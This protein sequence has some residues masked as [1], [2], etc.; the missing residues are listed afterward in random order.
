MWKMQK[1]G[2][3]KSPA[4]AALFVQEPSTAHR[5]CCSI[6]SC[7]NHLKRVGINTSDY[8]VYRRSLGHKVTQ[9]INSF[10]LLNPNSPRRNR[11][12]TF[13]PLSHISV[14]LF[15]GLNNNTK[16]HPPNNPKTA[17]EHHVPETN[18]AFDTD[19]EA[20]FLTQLAPL[21]TSPI[22]TI[23]EDP[24][25]SRCPTPPQLQINESLLESAESSSRSSRRNSRRCSGERLP[26]LVT[27]GG[28]M[29]IAF[30]L[31]RRNSYCPTRLAPPDR[32]ELL[33][34]ERKTRS[35][36][37]SQPTIVRTSS[38]R[39][40]HVSP[41]VRPINLKLL[42][43]EYSCDHLRLFAV[44]FFKINWRIVNGFTNHR[45]CNVGSAV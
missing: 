3:W 15:P 38:E 21:S 35:E 43:L 16:T 26:C 4:N 5:H 40:F 29:S 42:L 22:P 10:I 8:F 41:V 36:Q 39:R 12:Q 27:S 24:V 1:V 28:G 14:S 37:G 23:M 45:K 20:P 7:I 13:G 30:G 25:I 2:Y 32:Q 31:A 6:I 11:R 18:A 9:L 44:K 33:V 34:P 17:Q 19:E